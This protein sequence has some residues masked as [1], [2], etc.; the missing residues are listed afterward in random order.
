MRAWALAALDLVFPALCPL[1]Q[2][3]L[4]A[5]RRDPLCGPCWSGIERIAPPCCDACGRPFLGFERGPSVGQGAAPRA[6]GRCGTCRHDPPR[7]DYA[8]AAGVYAGALKDALHALKFAGKRGLAAPLGDLILAQCVDVVSADVTALIPVPLGRARRRARGFNQ[9]ALVAERVGRA[10]AV[11]VRA[12]WLARLT[13]T[14]PQ[15]ELSGSERRENVHHAFVASTAAA[16]R[17]VIVVDD[18]LTTGAT[19]GD[20]ARALRAAGAA[21]VGVL[22]VARV[23]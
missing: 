18:V 3:A 13:E 4:G 19:A 7:F 12:R 16:G 8:R 1:C 5:G 17:H 6:T 20:C 14:R 2:V 11:P 23:L 21:R 22:T 10:L 15:S 9:A